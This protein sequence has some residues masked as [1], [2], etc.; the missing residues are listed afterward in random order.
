M[1]IPIYQIDAFSDQLFSGNPAAVCPLQAWLPDDKLQAIAA[2]NNL[3]ETAFFVPLNNTENTYQLRWFTP[4]TE[5]DL[6]GHATLASAYVLFELLGIKA[7]RIC[8][9][10]RSGPLYVMKTPRGLTMDFPAAPLTAVAIPEHIEQGLGQTPIAAFAATDLML[11]FASE[12]Q[13]ID[14]AP[15]FRWLAQLP[16]RGIIA[17]APGTE[18]DFVSRFFAPACGI[19]EDPVT[20]SAHCALTPYWAAQLGKQQLSAR[21]LSRRGGSLLCELAE[22]RVLLSGTAVCYLSG[23]I[24]C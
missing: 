7:D 6:C 12:Q 16:Y 11:V 3:S 18:C 5:V 22:N 9:H 1:D 13:I 20:G 10:S 8:F 23:H 24:H 15:D 2:E 14:L 19:D 4:A 17:T 21:Q